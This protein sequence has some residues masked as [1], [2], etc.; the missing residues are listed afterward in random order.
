[1]MQGL[2]G[3]TE[4][5]EAPGEGEGVAVG[6]LAIFP[7]EAEW[8]FSALYLLPYPMCLSVLLWTTN[9]HLMIGKATDDPLVL[10][11]AFLDCSG[12]P[13]PCAR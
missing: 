7:Q 2:L 11:A 12:Q 13:V 4:S 10:A 9:P 1:M 5:G 6:C 8:S 3:D